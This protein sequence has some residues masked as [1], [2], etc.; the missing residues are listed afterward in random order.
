[1]I[2]ARKVSSY[3]RIEGRG[4]KF[5]SLEKQFALRTASSYNFLILSKLTEVVTSVSSSLRSSVFTRSGSKEVQSDRAICDWFRL[6]LPELL[7]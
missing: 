5:H 7:N 2:D 4:Q 6:L 1:M 3:S